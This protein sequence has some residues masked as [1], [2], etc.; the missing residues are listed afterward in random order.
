M[1]KMPK[2]PGGGVPKGIINLGVVAGL[3]IYGI[4]N[5]IYNVEGGHRAI[6]FNRVVGIKDKVL[7]SF[8]VGIYM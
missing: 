8:P 3:A 7:S 2:I 4:G 1:P 6:I 5:S